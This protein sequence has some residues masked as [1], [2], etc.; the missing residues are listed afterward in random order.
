MIF[1]K[2]SFFIYFFLII[3]IKLFSSFN[4]YPLDSDYHNE[5]SLEIKLQRISLNNP[6][7]INHEFL[8]KTQTDNKAIHL[9][10]VSKNINIEYKDKPNIMIVGQIH[11][12]EPVGL[13]VS[14]A[15]LEYLLDSKVLLEHYNFYIIPTLNPEGFA[16]VN[17]GLSSSHR[18]NKTDTNNNKKFD[19]ELDG[20]DLNRN[21]PVN[22]NVEQQNKPTERYY[23]GKHANSEFEVQALC[24]FF[25]KNHIFLLINYH[26]SINGVFNEKIFFP[27][28]W[29][30]A[31]SEHYDIMFYIANIMANKL[32]KD[33]F[34]GNYHVHNLK[35]S[36]VG[37]LRDY[38]YIQHNILSFDIEVG[39]LNRKGESIVFPN[40]KQL[41]KIVKKN[42][43][44]LNNLLLSMKDNLYKGLVIKEGDILSFNELFEDSNGKKK[45]LITNQYGYFFVYNPSK[46][47]TFNIYYN[48]TITP[49]IPDSSKRKIFIFN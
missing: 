36:K 24:D 4:K 2:K 38:A 18:K 44:S 35:T 15:F 42:L 13:E 6:D 40:N 49:Y 16:L 47:K 45:R 43:N 7:N 20:V 39:G 46:E 12:E 48:K 3:A 29:D 10:K 37:Y 41:R 5:S 19:I 9:I 32:Q 14:I 28:L 33:Y 31:V 25:Y 34:S 8:T 23:A 17:S 21:F 27:Y 22:W 11:S 1:D 30:D 26:S